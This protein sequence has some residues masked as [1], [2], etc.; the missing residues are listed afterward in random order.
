MELHWYA[1]KLRGISPGCQPSGFV[2]KDFMHG[3]FGAVAY[4]KPLS[5]EDVEAYD[6]EYVRDK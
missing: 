4:E 6:L 1:L 3:K 5:E 2:E